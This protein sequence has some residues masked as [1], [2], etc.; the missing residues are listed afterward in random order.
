MLEESLVQ[1]GGS[2]TAI[3]RTASV[4]GDRQEQ[5]QGWPRFRRD[6]LTPPNLVSLGRI[7]G[8]YVAMALYLWGFPLIGLIVGLAAGLSDYADGIL[9]RRMKLVT[10]LGAL[11]D[12]L[13]DM[14]MESSCILLAV[15]MGAWH[16]IFLYLYLFRNLT[17]VSIRM[18]AALRGQQIS[19]VFLGKMATNFIFYSILLVFIAMSGLLPPAS[20]RFLVW[21][22]GAGLSVGLLW[23]YL[24]MAIYVRR[25]VEGYSG[26]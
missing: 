24:S 9:A 21:L 12:Q 14:L 2:A 13:G 15:V 1:G 3:C 4:G 25:Y 16:P 22:S 10:P 23:G 7:A 20:A 17:N 8:V 18:A 11:L 19:S 5:Q 26:Q 6:L